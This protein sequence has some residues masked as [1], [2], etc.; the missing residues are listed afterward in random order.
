[1]SV[2][3]YFKILTDL[4]YKSSE[5]LSLFNVALLTAVVSGDVQTLVNSLFIY[6]LVLNNVKSRRGFDSELLSQSTNG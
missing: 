1:M 2:I 4:H 3:Q 5:I 6:L